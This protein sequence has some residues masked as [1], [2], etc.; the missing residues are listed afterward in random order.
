MGV[1]CLRIKKSIFGFFIKKKVFCFCFL[2][3]VVK[4]ILFY[5]KFWNLCP[6]IGPVTNGHFGHPAVPPSGA[7]KITFQILGT[8]LTIWST[9]DWP[10]IALWIPFCLFQHNIWKKWKG[11]NLGVIFETDFVIFNTICLTNSK[12][13]TNIL[14]PF[15]RRTYFLYRIATMGYIFF[16]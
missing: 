10:Q 4:K 11:I 14:T 15:F 8:F 7:Q 1:T 5:L 12:N 13:I 16:I 3:L 9:T 6:I 2:C